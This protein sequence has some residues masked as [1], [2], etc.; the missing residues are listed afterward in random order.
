MVIETEDTN[1]TV[2]SVPSDSSSEVSYI[3]IVKSED[4]LKSEDTET[5]MRK[6]IPKMSQV[7]KQIHTYKH[8]IHSSSNK[9]VVTAQE[10]IF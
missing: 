10:I 1:L 6:M 2:T 7:V 8:R 4:K 9:Y 5:E 3:V